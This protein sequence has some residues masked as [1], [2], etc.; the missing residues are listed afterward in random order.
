MEDDVE[1]RD[2]IVNNFSSDE[3]GNNEGNNENMLD[4]NTG[5]F[6]FEKIYNKL[7]Q[8]HILKEG[9]KCAKC[10]KEIKIVNDNSALD[11]KIFRCRGN[12]PNHDCKIKY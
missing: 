2:E 12:N 1:M 10:G 4:Y 11:K 7:L 8:M 3:E 5:E 6:E 9:F